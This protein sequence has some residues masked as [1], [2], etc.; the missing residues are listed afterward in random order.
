MPVTTVSQPSPTSLVSCLASFASALSRSSILAC[1]SVT[2]APL[3]GVKANRSADWSANSIL[4]NASSSAGAV[5]PLLSTESRSGI[6]V[7]ESTATRISRSSV[8]SV[9]FGVR[10]SS[11]AGRSATV[12]VPSTAT[13]LLSRTL[14]S[15]SLAA[16]AGSAVWPSTGLC[17]V[18]TSAGMVVL[19]TLLVLES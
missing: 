19:V 13:L 2:F 3:G 9:G 4:L 7:C 8:R 14:A 11:Y 6:R 18:A 1:F 12:A 15:S 17:L 5:V 10:T 16:V